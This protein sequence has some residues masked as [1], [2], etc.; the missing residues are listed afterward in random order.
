MTTLTSEDWG[1]IHKRA[2]T[3]DRFR[4]LLEHDPRAAIDEYGKE[5][6]KYFSTIVDV[7]PKP[8]DMHDDELHKHETAIVPPA[9]C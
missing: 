2:W 1:N 6:G 7:P 9:C 4:Q 8:S 5:V 3:D